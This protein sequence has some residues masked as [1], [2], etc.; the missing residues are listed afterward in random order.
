M[1]FLE[2]LRLKKPIRPVVRVAEPSTLRIEGAVICHHCDVVLAAP[3]RGMCGQYRHLVVP[4]RRIVRLAREHAQAQVAAF[5]MQRELRRVPL[6]ATGKNDLAT[7]TE[8]RKP[9]DAA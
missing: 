2:F 7:L 8:F 4:L 1:R 5:K 9:D 6:R 3:Q